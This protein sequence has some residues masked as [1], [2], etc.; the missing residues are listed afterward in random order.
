MGF[1]ADWQEKILTLKSYSHN[2]HN[3]QNR[4][5]DGNEDKGNSANTANIANRIPE[6]KMAERTLPIFCQEDCPWLESIRLSREGSVAGCANMTYWPGEWKRLGR[7]RGCPAKEKLPGLSLPEW[8]SRACEHY[9][10]T[11]L[12]NGQVMQKC[13][14]RKLGRNS[15]LL[16][17][18]NGCP[19]R[20]S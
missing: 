5:D 13:W 11:P 9:S 4:N 3:S 2:S 6:L 1:F 10:E 18:M 8:C 7:L 20:K 14:S 15:G 19:K 12:P 16:H 17:K